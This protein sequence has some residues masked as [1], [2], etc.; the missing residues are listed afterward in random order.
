M[1]L[2]CS[3]IN[4]LDSSFLT[5]NIKMLDS[6][7][8]QVL[9]ALIGCAIIALSVCIYITMNASS[10]LREIRNSRIRVI[11]AGSSVEPY[12]QEWYTNNKD[13]VGSVETVDLHTTPK[14]S[15]QD[16]NIIAQDIAKSYDNYDAFIILHSPDEIPYT[17]AALSFM[18]ENTKKPIIMSG[19]GLIDSLD[20]ASTARIPEVVVAS[21][22][23]LFRGCK[24]GPIPGTCVPLTSKN[25]FNIPEEPFNPMFVNP[26]VR[27]LVV[28]LFPGI[29]ATYLAKFL[30]DENLAGIVFET[31]GSMPINEDMLQVISSLAGNGVIMVAASQCGESNYDIDPILMEAG[32]LSAK[33]MTAAAAFAKLHFLLANVPERLIIGK[34]MEKSMRGEMGRMESTLESRLV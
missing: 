29:D 19:E 28:K 14:T 7:E 16:W 8:K 18:L 22:G 6:K 32:V 21:K 12:F 25:C 4:K 17:A 2:S 34:L 23:N 24:M 20:L 27:V 9:V 10:S 31:C 30:E 15:P 13:N 26:N 5:L 33:D 3:L 11:N 1:R